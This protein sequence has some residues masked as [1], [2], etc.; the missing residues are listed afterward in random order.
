MKKFLF[1]LLLLS[2]FLSVHAQDGILDPS[3][4]LDGIVSTDIANSEDVGRSVVVQADGKVIVAGNTTDSLNHFC[5]VRYHTDGAV[6]SSFGT[7]GIVITRFPPAG[8]IIYGL[9]LQSDGKILAGGSATPGFAL[10]RYHT[11]GSLDNSFG[12]SGI[13]TTSIQGNPA[14]A[15]SIAIQADGKIVL[16]GFS[17]N[18]LVDGS[19]C[20]V[21]RYNTDGS[22]DQTF[23]NGGIA[24]TDIIPGSG[25]NAVDQIRDLKVQPDGKIVSAGFAADKI[26]LIRHNSDGSLDQSFGSGGIIA[27]N[28]TGVIDAVAI[29]NNG[30]ITVAGFQNNP[31]SDFM[32]VRFDNSGNLDS[33][34]G[35]SGVVISP[36]G[37]KQDGAAALL[38]Q[39]DQKMLAGG[40]I[41]KDSINQFVLARYNTNG[42]LDPTF[43]TNGFVTT[44]AD[45]ASSAV[46]SLALQSDGNIIAAGYGYRNGVSNF[47]LARYTSGTVAIQEPSP[48]LSKFSVYPNPMMETVT[49]EYVLKMSGKVDFE[50]MNSNGQRIGDGLVGGYRE[51]GENSESFHV[52]HLS[53]GLYFVSIS[54]LEGKQTFKLIKE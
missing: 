42:T 40:L 20:V 48:F 17:N 9:A 31:Y 43:G 4:D 12:T 21:V 13:V 27:H 53:S 37:P 29:Q 49:I 32:L 16:G 34:F 50:I 41:F 14:V 45:S 18:F 8:S 2:Q 19:S 35:T 30:S 52:G 54:T 38:F 24:I 10:A 22:L 44:Q 28:T 36:L 6:D 5:L 23:S 3:F 26:A 51:K 33:T 11:D 46:T 25:L 39:A 15:Q 7:N 47:T 1:L